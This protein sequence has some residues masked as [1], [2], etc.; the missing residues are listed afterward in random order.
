MVTE[1][2]IDIEKLV[3][4]FSEDAPAGVDIRADVSPGSVYY[5]LKDARSAARATERAATSEDESSSLLPEWRLILDLAPRVL[6][7]TAKDLEV[8]AWLI[9]AL[10]RAHGFAGLRD[11]FILARRLVEDFWEGVYPLPDEDGLETRVAPFSG[12]NGEGGD[13]TLILPIRKVPLS[14]GE[15]RFAAW[16]Y[17]QAVELA[18]IAD[19]ER[20]QRR[21]DDG[22]MTLEAIEDSLNQCTPAFLRAIVADCDAAIAE[23]AALGEAFSA[24]AG[25]DA[26]PTSNIRNRLADIRR[27]LG[28]ASAARLGE[29]GGATDEAEVAAP[30]ELA[31]SGGASNA[32]PAPQGAIATREQ[33]F[34]L[35]SK[36]ADY[37]RKHEPQAPTAYVI[38]NLVRRGRLPFEELMAEL[39]EDPEARKR[40]TIAA[41]MKPQPED[42]GY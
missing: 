28:T 25:H 35:L 13:G 34:Q 14:E 12:L 2:V 7:E 4:P 30:A 29:D 33:A 5:Q 3:Q 18:Q 24:A 8:T 1:A 26:P 37:F 36:V 31:A 39:V 32:A 15:P 6:S 41:G 21:I 10:V 23:F 16:Q 9:E 27:F 22:A 20:R 42:N 17:D 38:D 40:L 19:A 11:G